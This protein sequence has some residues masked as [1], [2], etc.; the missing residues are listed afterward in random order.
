MNFVVE[1]ENL[2]KYFYRGQKSENA[3]FSALHFNQKKDKFPVLENINFKLQKGENLGIIGRNG[4]GKSTLL[5]VIAGIYQPDDGNVAVKGNAVYLAGF[6]KGLKDKLTMRENIFLMGS[7]MDLSRKDIGDKLEEIVE[8]SGLKEYLDSPVYQFSS[9]M[10][11][12][13]NFSIGIHCIFHKNPDILLID[14]AIGSGADIDFQEK[15][16]AKMEELLNSGTSVIF[17]SHSLDQIEKYCNR[18][19]WLDK[20]RILTEGKP[21]EII[22]E[23]EKGPSRTNI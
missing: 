23:Y 9:G 13:L 14:E 2:S 4:S 5:R 15:S 7:L 10:V 12:R 18:V 3:L 19:L 8:F 1:V 20:G 22:I 11:S 21:K 17:V 16:L 6:G